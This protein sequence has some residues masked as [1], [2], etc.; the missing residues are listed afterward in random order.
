[1]SCTH[2]GL[3]DACRVFGSVGGW[4]Q[5]VRLDLIILFTWVLGAEKP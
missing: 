5:H 3:G 1:M 2:S 4:A